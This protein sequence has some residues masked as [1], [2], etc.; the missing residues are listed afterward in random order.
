[1]LR[2]ALAREASSG[3]QG[4]PNPIQGSKTL[5]RTASREEQPLEE[6]CSLSVPHTCYEGDKAKPPRKTPCMAKQS[7]RGFRSRLG[8]QGHGQIAHCVVPGEYLRTWR[9]ILPQQ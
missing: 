9:L 8:L 4:T 7:R 5:R 6:F 2:S 3:P 1:M